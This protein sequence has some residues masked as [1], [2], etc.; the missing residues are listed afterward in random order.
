MA[1]PHWKDYFRGDIRR[2]IREADV[3][4]KKYKEGKGVVYLQQACNKLFS[5]VENLL[6]VKYGKQEKSFQKILALAM[7]NQDDRTLLNDSAQLHYFFYNGETHMLATI[8][9]P[10]YKKVR[11]RVLNRTGR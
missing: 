10:L 3:E 8:A 11:E 5:A 2:K 9:E 7:N 6:M 1:K 4:Y